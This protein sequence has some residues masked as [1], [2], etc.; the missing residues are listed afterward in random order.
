M[1]ALQLFIG[2]RCSNDRAT[3]PIGETAITLIIYLPNFAGNTFWFSK[4]A[5]QDYNSPE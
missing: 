3:Y 4:P 2:Y 5:H 1:K